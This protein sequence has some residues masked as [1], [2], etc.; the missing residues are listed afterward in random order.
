MR[1]PIFLFL[2]TH[3]I[4]EQFLD[5]VTTV[6]ATSL[7]S[8]A[9]ALGRAPGHHRHA[10]DQPA[11]HSPFIDAA[12]AGRALPALL[13]A[14][15]IYLAIALL[16]QGLG[17]LTTYL[18]TDVGWRATNQLREDVVLHCLTLDRTFH[19]THLMMP[20]LVFGLAYVAVFV[21]GD[22]LH[23]RG[24]MSVGTVYLVIHYLGLL[25]APLDVLAIR[26]L[27]YRYP[28]SANGIADI[29]L[30]LNRGTLTVIT[31]QVG[32]GKTTLLRTLL[33][34]LPKESGEI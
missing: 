20:I 19:K 21:L 16:E 32:A 12:E 33:G 24:Q 31:G 13:G 26:N 22:R 14:A 9:A 8:G 6:S 28:G 5:A 25:S 27:S 7:G 1:P 29:S 23:R 18:S 34:L 15:G 10:A 17:L 3:P 11:D 30:R 2:L 4:R